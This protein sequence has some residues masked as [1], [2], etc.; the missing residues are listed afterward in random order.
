MKALIQRVE[1]ASVEIDG[2]VVSY[3]SRGILVLLGVAVGDEE[4]DSVFLA[5]KCAHL[6]IFDD[7]GGKMN[8]SLLDIDGEALVVSQFTLYGDVSKGRRPNYTAAAQSETAEPLYEGFVECL[9]DAGVRRVETGR[10][11][12]KMMVSLVNDGP[13]TLIVESPGDSARNFGK[14]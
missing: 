1:K 11:G 6:R 2:E 14:R 4:G 7:E 8:L 12:A 5:D 13:V 9:R 10:F 3:I